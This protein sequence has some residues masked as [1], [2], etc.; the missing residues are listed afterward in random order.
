M[1]KRLKLLFLSFGSVFALTAWSQK[2]CRD[3][4]NDFI[5]SGQPEMAVAHADSCLEKFRRAGNY[6]EQ[7]KLIS[8]KARA[9][10]VQALKKEA[11][12]VFVSGLEIT[13]KVTDPS[14]LGGFYMDIGLLYYR[15]DQFAKA[16]E[17]FK[18]S[19]K[20]Y[21]KLKHIPAE[22]YWIQNNLDNI[23]LCYKGM[24]KLGEAGNY[25]KMAYDESVLNNNY[26]GSGVALSNHAELMLEM[27]DT[28]TA[29]SMLNRAVAD[30]RKS[31]K[32]EDVIFS[33]CIT[34]AYVYHWNR[35]FKKLDSCLL[36]LRNNESMMSQINRSDYEKLLSEYRFEKGN[37]K[38]AF[39]H[40]KKYWEIKEELREIE[41]KA[42]ISAEVTKA[43]FE[44]QKKRMESLMREGENT[45]N[46]MKLYVSFA[47]GLGLLVILLIGLVRSS[48]RNNKKL[49]NLNQTIKNHNHHVAALNKNLEK[50]NMQKDYVIATVAHDLRNPVGSIKIFTEFMKRDL[51][52]DEMGKEELITNLD[53]IHSSCE[54]ALNTINELV[55]DARLNNVAE[56]KIEEC[57]LNQIIKNVIRSQRDSYEK[58]NIALHF[59]ERPG[60]FV[61]ADPGKLNRVFENLLSNALKFSYEGKNVFIKI[62]DEQ[63]R[64]EF[65]VEVKDEG[66]GISKNHLDRLFEPF[67]KMNRAGTKGERSTGLGLSI[68]KKIVELHKGKIWAESKEGEGTSFYVALKIDMD[69]E[70]VSTPVV[71]V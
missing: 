39:L 19:L 58:K 34:L 53:I 43:E 52:N 64:N 12:E 67:D 69:A 31:I 5:D 41:R 65:V 40:L 15:E 22:R 10:T 24:G 25:Y 54:N 1:K 11:L 13:E 38:E 30:L 55:E 33:C 48:N 27:G 46:K 62:F 56:L 50:A 17:Y 2:T 36:V 70:S 4:V 66:T 8:P 14:I 63:F 26:A 45:S 57:D 18:L 42:S 44:E 29:I 59:S 32:H 47:I 28:P 71:S 21:E 51:L 3:I 68:T 20:Q 35:N 23:A 60:S 9:F 49:L 7:L 16:M 37:Y 6:D 61:K